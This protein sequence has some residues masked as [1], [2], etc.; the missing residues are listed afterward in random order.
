MSVHFIFKNGKTSRGELTDSMKMEFRPLIYDLK[1]LR[2]TVV[3][4]NEVNEFENMLE[5]AEIVFNTD[6]TDYFYKSLFD[7][8]DP[9]RNA[10]KSAHPLLPNMKSFLS[11]MKGEV[12]VMFDI[13]YDKYMRSH[14]VLVNLERSAHS[15][16]SEEMKDAQ[17]PIPEWL[18]EVFEQHACHHPLPHTLKD[19]FVGTSKQKFIYDDL[20]KKCGRLKDILEVFRDQIDKIGSLDRFFTLFPDIEKLIGHL[21][22]INSVM[23]SPEDHEQNWQVLGEIDQSIKESAAINNTEVD[24]VLEFE[25]F[26]TPLWEIA[27]EMT[28]A[29]VLMKDLETIQKSCAE[30]P[31]QTEEL[32]LFKAELEAR[33]AFYVKLSNVLDQT[34]RII[35]REVDEEKDRRFEFSKRDMS[36]WHPGLV[37]ILN[38]DIMDGVTEPKRDMSGVQYFESVECVAHPM[39]DIELKAENSLEQKYRALLSKN[40]EL[41]EEISFLRLQKVNWT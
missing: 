24:F 13:I 4:V 8:V 26:F 2:P 33:N 31:N 21:K 23:N 19:F 16:G 36:E 20:C 30:E 38:D 6:L 9:L 14:Q 41:K 5:P 32:E 35:Q 7:F 34:S 15:N 39:H 22:Y 37:E 18:C 29:F 27:E 12:K 1:N 10:I 25:A 17:E 3:V 40:K 28:N 11:M